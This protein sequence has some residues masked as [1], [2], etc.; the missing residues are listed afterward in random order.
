MVP[1]ISV[2]RFAID[3][4]KNSIIRLRSLVTCPLIL[5]P[6]WFMI[7]Y[8]ST[9]IP[10]ALGVRILALE[11]GKLVGP[12][13]GIAII[14]SNIVERDTTGNRKDV[15]ALMLR[16]SWVLVHISIGRMRSGLARL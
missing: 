6:R 8:R 16:G 11:T 9:G 7:S 1:Q 13:N 15:N 5:H 12:R 14:R 2:N 3:V 4:V 10:S